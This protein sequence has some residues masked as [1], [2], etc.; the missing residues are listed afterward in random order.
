MKVGSPQTYSGRVGPAEIEFSSSHN[1]KFDCYD[2]GGDHIAV[3]CVLRQILKSMETGCLRLET[4]FAREHLIRMKVSEWSLLSQTYIFLTL[5]YKIW[6]H[7]LFDYPSTSSK[8]PS[9]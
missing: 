7:P 8:W 9:S 1:E 6:L 5:I 3:F 2:L 4:I